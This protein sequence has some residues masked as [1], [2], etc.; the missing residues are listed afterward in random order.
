MQRLTLVAVGAILLAAGPARAAEVTVTMNA[1]GTA[2][3]GD[4]LGTIA[5]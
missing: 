2:G 5:F 1:V 3:V 4:L